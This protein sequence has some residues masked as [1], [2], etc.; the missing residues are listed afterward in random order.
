MTRA[1]RLPPSRLGLAANA[2]AAL[3]LVTL[4][5]PSTLTHEVAVGAVEPRR[6]CHRRQVLRPYS[7]DA[8]ASSTT[9]KAKAPTSPS[10][11]PVRACGPAHTSRS[12]A[13]SPARAI[14][15]PLTPQ[16]TLNVAGGTLGGSP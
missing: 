7:P 12:S 11:R 4:A 16:T 5:V 6:F 3:T 9:S 1:S 15:I 14:P 13:A 8:R 2:R 10:S